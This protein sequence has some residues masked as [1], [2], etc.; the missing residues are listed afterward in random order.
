MPA[1]VATAW[2]KRGV[3]A[4][5]NDAGAPTRNVAVR[6]PRGR[7]PSQVRQ[8]KL[9]PFGKTCPAQSAAYVAWPSVTRSVAE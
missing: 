8:P 7:P 6:L 9:P 5:P 1:G 2:A 4:R 3:Q